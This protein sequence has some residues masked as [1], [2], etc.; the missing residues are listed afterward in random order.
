[1]PSFNY[2]YSTE[3]TD[4]IGGCYEELHTTGHPYIIDSIDEY[5]RNHSRSE[6][7]GKDAR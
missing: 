2:L 4:F 1:M 7:A 3:A 6:A 5:I